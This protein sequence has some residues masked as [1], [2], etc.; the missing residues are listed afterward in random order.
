MAEQ[1]NNEG[2]PRQRREGGNGGYRKGGQHGGHGN[3]QG[4]PR[5]DGG[6]GGFGGR[7]DRRGGN[8]GQGG[9]GGQRRDG[10]KGGYRGRDGEKRDFRGNGGRDERR[11]GYKGDRGPKCDFKRE[12]IE[13]GQRPEAVQH[14]S[15]DRPA[16]EPKPD[17]RGRN[18]ARDPRRKPE[19]GG[20]HAPR[21]G[22]KGGFRGSAKPARPRRKSNATPARLAALDVVRTVRERNA[23]AQDVIAQVIDKS[24]MSVEDRAFAT[25]LALGTVSARGT[26]DEIIDRALDTPEDIFR[27]TRDALQISTYELIFLGKEAHAAVDQG[28]EMVKSFSPGPAARVAN[29]VLHKIVRLRIDFPFG[30]PATD[31]DALARTQAFPT[32]MAKK[33]MEEMGPQAAIE[34][35]RA[36]NEQ[37]PLYVAV[38]ACKV[39]DEHVLKAFERAEEEVQPVALGDMNVQ[40]CLRVPESRALLVPA[41]ARQLDQ[42]KILVSDAAA[43]MVAANV[44]PDQKPASVLEIGAG[45]ATKTIL[46]QSNACRKYGSQIEE[47]V[48]IDNHAYKTRLLEKRAEQYGVVVTEA[49]TGNALELDNIM[50]DRMFSFIFVD[51]P[52]SGM[53]TLR[54]HPE[55]R[56]RTSEEDLAGFVETQLGMLKAAAGH[57]APG[58]ALA[59]STCTVTREENAGVVKAFLDSE[60]GADFTLDQLCGRNCLATRLAPGSS[61][62]HFAVRFVRKPQE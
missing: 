11:G 28:V 2:A 42:G 34:F 55:I 53:G 21:G 18:T 27:E 25:L 41:L 52:C 29:A 54:R 36:S 16:R 38:N 3:R 31:L 6:K 7:D 19:Q 44:L 32:W 1:H 22:E 49:F 30:N 20:Q 13:G 61:D 9:R 62:A 45:R 4:G 23:F 10:G 48:T 59:Y 5:R 57:V 17:F 50:P 12:G 51:A 40:G 46:L 15:S 35:M 33:L 8:R 37:A 43:Q 58:G 24:T 26:L 47:Y 56:W 14:A 60:E 39:D